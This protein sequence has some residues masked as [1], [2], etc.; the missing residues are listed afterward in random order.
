MRPAAVSVAVHPSQ[1]LASVSPLILGAGMAVWYDITT[2]GVATSLAAAG[3]EATRWPGGKA[4]NW[5]HWKTNSSGP[6]ACSG[7]PNKNS[8]FDNFMHDVAIR[9]HLDVAITVNYGSNPNCTAGGDPSE[10]AGW[11]AYANATQNYNV[12]WWTVG[13]EQWAAGA[14]D[15]HSQPHSPTQYAQIVASDFYPAMKAASPTPINV[16]VGVQPKKRGWDPTVLAQAQYDCVEMHFYAQSGSGPIS[17]SYL[18]QQAVPV[19]HG[20]LTTL[21]SELAAAG[22]SN[23]PIYLGEI[24]SSTSPSGKQSQSIVQAL[25]AGQVVGELVNSGVARATW[26]LGNGSCDL[27]SAGGDFSS[28]IYGW[29]NWWGA[30]ILADEQQNGCPTQYIPPETLLATARAYQ[31]LANFAHAGEAALATTVTSMPDIR[32]YATTDAGGYAVM[33]FN[34]NQT[35]T[36][37][38]GV[39]IDG[40]SSG[41]G[42]TIVTYDK[43]L[44]DQTQNNVWAG[45]T[46]ASLGSWSGSFDVSMPPWSM[47]VVQTQ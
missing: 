4:A 17:D 40:K 16:C 33:L 18:L 13:N 43:D 47:V 21:K 2:P 34:L 29:Q 9:A 38:V 24:G 32:A 20:Y 42:G 31:V 27:P 1:V 35:T 5:Y 41:S 7:N 15:L 12:Q 30:M 45:P 26:H 46:S 25:F 37:D 19:L 6:G 3:L 14:I 10:A 11:V 39:S 28:S 23:A 44:Y 36:E 8:T 22:H